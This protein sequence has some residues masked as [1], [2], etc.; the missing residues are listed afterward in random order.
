M[1]SSEPPRRRWL[2]ALLLPLVAVPAACGFRLRGSAEL[3]FE[4]LFVSFPPGSATGAEFI[5]LLRVQG[6]TR[7]VERATDAQARL[8]VYTERREKEIVG[9][10]STGRPREYQLRLITGFRLVDVASGIEMIPANDL[11]LRREITTTD[12]QLVAKQQEEVLLYREMQ[13]D[14]VQQLLRRLAAAR[15]PGPRA[16]PG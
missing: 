14:T 13:T 15:R 12:T 6:G 7:L 8:E 16:A 5:R 1:W 11:I 9:F 2:R 3:P 10:S 4:T